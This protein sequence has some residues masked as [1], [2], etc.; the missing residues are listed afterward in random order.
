MKRKSIG[1]SGATDVVSA[2]LHKQ[3]T[4]RA[5]GTVVQYNRSKVQGG[6]QGRGIVSRA[7]RAVPEKLHEYVRSVRVLVTL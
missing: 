1:N 7:A 6:P 3:N 5:W 2:H 4:S